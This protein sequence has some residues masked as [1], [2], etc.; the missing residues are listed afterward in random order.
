MKVKAPGFKPV[1]RA[2]L[3][4][5][6]LITMLLSTAAPAVAASSPISSAITPAEMP[7]NAPDSAGASGVEELLQFTADRHVLGFGKRQ[8]YVAGMDHVLRVEFAG[9]SP[10]QPA[11]EG[12]GMAQDGAAPL[13]KVTR[14]G[15]W[16]GVDIVYSA[17][18][19]GIA[20]STYYLNFTERGLPVDSIRLRYNR[21]LSIDGQGNLVIAF[22]NGC[23]IESA[24]AAWQE[25]DGVKRPVS[26]AFVLYGGQEAGFA[27]NDYLPGI[28]VVI[29][30]VLTWNT[31]LGGD[32]DDYG[33]GITV[34]GSGNVYVTGYSCADWGS[35][36]QPFTA[37]VDGFA[38]KLNVATGA[39]VW[40]TFLGGAR[41]DFGY[42]IAADGGGNVYVAGYSNGTW[43]DPVRDYEGDYD[44]FVARLCDNGT[45]SWNTF[46]GAGGTDKGY[47][48]AAD[49][50]GNVYV[51]GY[52]NAAWG[53]PVRDYEGD[54]D[55]FAA[56]L[57]DNGTLSWNTFLGGDGWDEG[58]AI[59]VDGGNVYVAGDSTATWQGA[60]PPVRTF[61]GS[62][63]AF[64]AVLCDNGTL[65]WN[66]FLGG[67]GWDEGYA[68]TVDCG[69]VYVAGYSNATWQ[70]ADPPVRAFQGDKDAFAA[71]LNGSTGALSWNTFLGSATWD[72]GNAIAVD[73][74]NVY[75]TGGSDAAWGSPVRA[76]QGGNDAFAARLNGATG[77][78]SWNTFLGGPGADCG[79]GIASHVAGNVYVAGYSTATWQGANPPVR[80]FQGSNDAFAAKIAKAPPTL[81]TNAASSIGT[82]SATLNMSYT[83]G[84]YSSV[85]VRFAYKISADP[86][87]TYTSWVSKSAAGTHAAPLTGLDSNTQYDFKAELKYDSAEIP[88]STLQFTTGTPPTPTP[89]PPPPPAP[90]ASPSPPTLT[91][92]PPP[93]I[94]VHSLAV[95][96]GE[97]QSGQPV[98]VLANVV[99]NGV[100]SGSYNVAL[101]VNGRVE[102]QRMVE[103]SPGTAYPVR[104]TVTKTQPGTYD[105]AIEGQKASFT[106]IGG[107]STSAP[108]SGGLIALI[109][110]AVLILATAVVLM[111][112]F[113]R[114]AR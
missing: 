101:R 23:M 104:F 110:I 105:V 83:V 35:P 49:G 30:P 79:Y 56:V 59:T 98:T 106:V 52:S 73:G 18:E 4:A 112:A 77:A 75:V 78:L 97:T 81:I 3:T 11:A 102:Q 6:M 100:S 91:R 55:A 111:I 68:I 44:A 19:G 69:N 33:R 93:D 24:P 107:A 2:S 51:A 36:V 27:L 57:C 66:T 60:N 10:V 26:A 5:M 89:T 65:S 54:Y 21:P 95:S 37:L 114:P 48:I 71:R 103:V 62:N 31:F 1:L 22:D 29:D 85:D 74:G 43:G 41:A 92:L 15:V 63:D 67:A 50:G 58:H 28:P 76:F 84:D 32:D 40:N 16:P 96:P 72:S 108:A 9:G 17:A 53:S 45:L 87:W 61:Q 34:D 82:N 86:A 14:S 94:R 20:E 88:D 80:T 39:L 42:A 25:V 47:A 90:R 99:N 38:A 7:V 46:L 109:V 70:G 113:R 12:S 64:A 13:E 8:V